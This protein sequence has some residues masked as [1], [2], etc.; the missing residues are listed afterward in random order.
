MYLYGGCASGFGPCPLGDLWSYDLRTNRWTEIR[1]TGA[2]PSPRERYGLGFDGV[3][4]RLVVYG[5]G[6]NAGPSGDLWEYDLASGTWNSLPARTGFEPRWRHE[7]AEARDLGLVFYFGGEVRGQLSNE[8]VQYRAES[9]IRNAFSNLATPVAP[10]ELRTVYGEGLENGEVRVNGVRAPV[11]FSSE[12]QINFQV[13]ESTTGPAALI[14]VYVNGLI[15]ISER[16]DFV[17][18]SP[19]LAP[20]TV[21]EAGTVTVWATGVGLI[22]E[23]ELRAG[24]RLLPLLA[25]GTPAAG[26]LQVTAG[27]DGLA[28]GDY[29]LRLKAGERESQPG[30]ILQ[31]R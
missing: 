24:G 7:A 5:G 28:T 6:T 15:R 14:E 30:L 13:P 18:S 1:P 8:L 22:N 21:V 27:I 29:E 3:R 2:A 9:R 17:S 20:Q 4:N 23:I 31:V 10:G 12:S 16:L 25:I 11:L 26:V 19:A